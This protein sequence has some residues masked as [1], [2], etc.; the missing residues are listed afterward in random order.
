MA[1]TMEEILKIAKLKNKIKELELKRALNLEEQESYA[2]RKE[3]EIDGLEREL[4]K[5]NQEK[6]FMLSLIHI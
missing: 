1:K 3:K 6:E 2:E 5:S 4:R